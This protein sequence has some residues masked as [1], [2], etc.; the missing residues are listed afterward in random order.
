M[1]NLALWVIAIALSVGVLGGGVYVYVTEQ[2]RAER[3]EATQLALES[4]RKRQQLQQ[5]VNARESARRILMDVMNEFAE[6]IPSPRAMAQLGRGLIERQ[7]RLADLSAPPCFE[8]ARIKTIN[9]IRQVAPLVEIG[10]E[11]SSMALGTQLSA[12][13]RLIVMQARTPALVTSAKSAEDELLSA[14]REFELS[15]GG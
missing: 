7:R 4:A 14:C 9:A 5:S 13:V 11:E 12:E 15:L 10:A 3:E 1:K 6:G 8:L 2:R